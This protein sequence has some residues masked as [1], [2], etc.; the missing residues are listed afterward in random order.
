MNENL[1]LM[2]KE[3]ARL[4]EVAN[5]Y[6]VSIFNDFKLLSA[7]GAFLGAWQPILEGINGGANTVAASELLLIGFLVIRVTIAL[8]GLQHLTKQSARN[9]YIKEIKILEEEIV[10]NLPPNTKA[11]HFVEKWDSKWKEKHGKVAIR[12]YILLGAVALFVPTLILIL[13]ENYWHSFIYAGFSLL[14]SVVH[15]STMKL[16]DSNSRS[17]LSM[18]VE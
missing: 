12:F 2:Y 18:P 10:K 6:A 15:F 3:R 17:R 16:V 8:I 7:L 5:S 13:S 9:I 4:A 14:L 11:F 1:E